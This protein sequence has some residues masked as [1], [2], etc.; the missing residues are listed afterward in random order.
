MRRGLKVLAGTAVSVALVATLGA[1]SAFGVSGVC[2][3]GT[4]ACGGRYYTDANADDVCDW[5][6]TATGSL[7]STVNTAVA[8]AQTRG[9]QASAQTTNQ[10]A[11]VQPCGQCGANYVDAN[12]DGVC[13]NC[14]NGGVRPQDGTGYH[15]GWSDNTASDT[16]AGSSTGA[17]AGWGA[18]SGQGHHGAGH[19]RCW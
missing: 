4:N 18:H 17:G 2:G 12:G 5:L 9:T 3:A 13:D 7:A 1:T 19:G 16:G 14:P 15:H 11:S 10:A 8:N 6:G